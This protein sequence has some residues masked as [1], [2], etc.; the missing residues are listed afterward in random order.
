MRK[1]LKAVAGYFASFD[2]STLAAGT[3]FFMILSIFPLLMLVLSLLRY[4]PWTLQDLLNMLATVLPEPLMGTVSALMRELYT[5]NLLAVISVTV[6]VALWSASRGVFGIINGINT[7]MGAEEHRSY[8]RRRLTAIFYTFLMIIA[9]FLTLGLQVFGRS[10][11]ALIDRRNIRILEAIAHLIHQRNLFTT[12]MLTLLFTAIYAFFPAKHMRLRHVVPP[13][14][15]AA[16]GWLVFSYLFSIYVDYGGGS[17]FYGSMTT[18]ILGML[19]LY[20]CMCILFWGGVLCRLSEENRL[21]L[22]ALKRFLS[23]P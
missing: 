15:L 12:A 11:L 23:S 1:K 2:V 8:L 5:S 6:L 17:R 22:K 13:A 10:L 4:L 16:V 3:S 14:L 20:I 9:L 19:W 7:I 18:V 21:G